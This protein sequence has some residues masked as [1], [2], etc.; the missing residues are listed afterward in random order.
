MTTT[1]P[2]PKAALRPKA[3]QR[4]DSLA[5]FMAGDFIPACQSQAAARQAEAE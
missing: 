2:A 4:E 1:T 3:E 5:P